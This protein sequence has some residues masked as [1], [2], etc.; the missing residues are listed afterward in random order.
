[1]ETG[2]S[3]QRMKQETESKT[4]DGERDSRLKVRQQIEE[5]TVL[6]SSA[7]IVSSR[8]ELASTSLSL[9]FRLRISAL[10][11]ATLSRFSRHV[12]SK[13]TF[14]CRMPS[15]CCWNPW[16]FSLNSAYKRTQ[17]MACGMLVV[18]EGLLLPSRHVKNYY[19]QK[20]MNY[21][22]YI[23]QQKIYKYKFKKYI[24]TLFIWKIVWCTSI[25]YWQ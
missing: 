23:K 4:G 12:S 6:L 15:S 7:S 25:S 8:P 20:I 19:R 3:R 17:E 13:A 21:K 11:D 18:V 16:S 24:S 9:W 1:M 22:K 14:C 10:F 5:L 2:D